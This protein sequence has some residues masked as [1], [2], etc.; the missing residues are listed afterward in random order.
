MKQH[1]ITVNSELENMR[2][3]RY[4]KKICS[5]EPLSKIFKALRKGDVRVNDLKVKE[6]YRLNLN[7]I[8]T[9]KYLNVSNEFFADDSIK[10]ENLVNVKI[11]KKD[12]N[13]FK[14][15]IIFENDD[16]FVV[17]KPYGIP[18]HKGTG[19]KYGLSEIF[20]TIYMNDNVNFANRLDRETSGLVIGCKTKK[21][22]RYI[23]EKIRNHEIDKHYL[24]ICKGVVNGNYNENDEFIMKI[25]NYLKTIEEKVIV[26]NKKDKSSKKA[27]S[28]FTFYKNNSEKDKFYKR[29]ILDLIE[30]SSEVGNKNNST[31]K[32][33]DSTVVKVEL[34][35]GRKHQIRVQLDHL[36]YPILGDRKYS[37]IENE[38]ERL[39]LVCYKLCFD[40]YEF[41]LI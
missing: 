12:V 36:G 4:L 24:A 28:I 40:N 19:Q 33:K 30:Q 9:I 11:N 34:I 31:S 39:N 18:M 8:I 7:D 35:T 14:N 16:F 37:K 27:E 1:E 22:T 26:T 25:S 38:N 17:N 32:Y 2:I 15:K 6:N 10:F 29:K 23:T 5:D 41:L 20:K 21:F 13:Y 3:D